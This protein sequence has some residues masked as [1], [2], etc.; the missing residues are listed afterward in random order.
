MAAGDTETAE[1]ALHV[2]AVEA[3]RET[4]PARAAA[5]FARCH[6]LL[7]RAPADLLT[8]ARHYEE[9]A[10]PVELA[11]T[12]EDAAVVLAEAG[13]A[14]E[15]RAAHARAVGH[16]DAL[17]AV[18]LARRADTRL[19]RTGVAVAAPRCANNQRSDPRAG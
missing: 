12:L 14:D 8:A 13:R 17:G 15:A 7:R 3:E 19:A 10:R 6:G 5:A 4:V 18:W 2:C 11:Q 9:V 1:H 16:Y